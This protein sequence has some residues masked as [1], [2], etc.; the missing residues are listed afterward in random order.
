MNSKKSLNNRHMK[1]LLAKKERLNSM[2]PFLDAERL[3]Y[4]LD[5]MHGI[6]T[7]ISKLI[8]SAKGER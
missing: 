1:E 6:D 5:E 2:L 3:N 7:E 4:V 8:V